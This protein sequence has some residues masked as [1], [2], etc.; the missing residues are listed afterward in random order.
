MGSL[1]LNFD[2]G[3]ALTGVAVEDS[4]VG[5]LKT[6]AKKITV[7]N[8]FGALA[9]GPH[10]LNVSIADL[11]GNLSSLAR[12]FSIDTSVPDT[13][14]T[15]PAP[16]PQ[17]QIPLDSIGTYEGTSTDAVSPLLSLR[18]IVTNPLGQ[19]KAFEI[20]KVCNQMTTPTNGFSILSESNGGKTW[21]WRWVGPTFDLHM[22]LPGPY[23]VSVVAVDQNQNIEHADSTNSAN[24]LVI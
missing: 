1:S 15:T 7:A 18:A 22:L 17:I 9:D 21:N 10:T 13:A 3:P 6:P 23:S 8:A 2:G 20:R 16:S 12:P 14:M 4:I 19:Q 11:D 24:V 5:A